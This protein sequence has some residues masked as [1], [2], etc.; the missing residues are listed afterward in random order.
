[1]RRSVLPA[2][3]LPDDLLEGF[4]RRVRSV[5][6]PANKLPEIMELRAIARELLSHINHLEQRHEAV[7]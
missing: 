3:R 6:I 2:K 4:E 7:A 5:E 1:M